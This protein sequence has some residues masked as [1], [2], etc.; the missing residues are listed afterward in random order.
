MKFNIN[1]IGE[2]DMGSIVALDITEKPD[3]VTS[4]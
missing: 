1:L 2:K 3:G 4:I